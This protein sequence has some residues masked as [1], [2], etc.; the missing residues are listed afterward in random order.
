MSNYKKP[1][2]YFDEDLAEKLSIKIHGVYPEFE[3]DAFIKSITANLNNKTLKQRV[4]LMADQL[5][6]H[7]PEN[8]PEATSIL[9]EI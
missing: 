8:Y 9:M 1:T 4:E 7:L 6:N 2:D 5:K 3:E